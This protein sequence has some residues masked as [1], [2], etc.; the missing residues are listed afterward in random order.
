[1]AG[2]GIVVNDSTFNDHDCIVAGYGMVV[3]DIGFN[4]HD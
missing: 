2:Y 4:D 1:M 3:N